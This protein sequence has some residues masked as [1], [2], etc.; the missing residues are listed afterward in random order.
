MDNLNNHFMYKCSQNAIQN[1]IQMLFSKIEFWM[2]AFQN[3]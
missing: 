1:A 2:H 3:E